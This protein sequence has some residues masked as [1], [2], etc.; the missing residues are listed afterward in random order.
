MSIAGTQIKISN[1]RLPFF[2]IVFFGIIA[3]SSVLYWRQQL[4]NSST[5]AGMPLI[6]RTEGDLDPSALRSKNYQIEV[7]DTSPSVK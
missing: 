4:M 3:F 7:T 5:Y 1:P 6:V 2:L